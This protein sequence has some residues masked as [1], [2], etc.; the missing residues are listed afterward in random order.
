MVE[1]AQ[2][3]NAAVARVGD[4]INELQAKADA[5]EQVQQMF[6][7]LEAKLDQVLPRERGAVTVPNPLRAN[8]GRERLGSRQL[9]R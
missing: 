6:A 4:A 7:R 2:A 5:I 3:A 9:R 8:Y 1:I